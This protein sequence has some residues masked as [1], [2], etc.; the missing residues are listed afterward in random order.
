MTGN[1]ISAA[2]ALVLPLACAALCCATAA[3]PLVADPGPASPPGASA[4]PVV[5]AAADARPDTIL[6]M[7]GKENAYPRWSGDGRRILFQSNRNGR[8][9]IFVMERDGSG[10]HPLT[11]GDANDNFPDWSPDGRRV[12]FVSD[13][14]GDEE[15]WVMDLDGGNLRNLSRH[16]GRDIHPYWAPDGQALLFNSN[17]DAEESFEIYRVDAAG[18]GLRR[19]TWTA[20][21]ETCARFSPDG[22]RIV[23]LHGA[24][25]DEIVL[26]D[27][28][29][30]HPVNLTRTA[31]AEGWPAWSPDGRWIVYS[32]NASGTFCL[33]RMD[34]DGGSREQL[35]FVD[36]P[37]RDARAHVSPDGAYL[38]FNR[39][40]GATIGILAMPWPSTGP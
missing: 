26:L 38:L 5:A 20:A 24:D 15:V 8:W 3:A 10:E 25:N 33:Y 4:G 6:W 37:V 28:K 12:A 23:C 40:R 34:R 21:V 9:Q 11:S 14:T 16:P 22:R 35:T 27:A 30:Q 2:T 36:A 17:R 19:M 32:S 18:G 1:D 39:Q 29:G 7:E 31:A 13:R